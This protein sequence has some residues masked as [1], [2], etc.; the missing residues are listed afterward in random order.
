[1]AEPLGPST[2]AL[3]DFKGH[4]IRIAIQEPL[5]PVA[6][7][8]IELEWRSR[9]LY[10]FDKNTKLSIVKPKEKDAIIVTDS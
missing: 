5:R 7:D 8:E 2:L 9:H 3:C 6:G 4:E 10:M 1:M